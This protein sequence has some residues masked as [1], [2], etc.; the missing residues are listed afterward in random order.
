MHSLVSALLRRGTSHL[1]PD[2]ATLDRR[3][4]RPERRADD[5]LHAVLEAFFRKRLRTHGGDAASPPD[6][7]P[8]LVHRTLNRVAH[9]RAAGSRPG[10]DPL[11]PPLRRE[12]VMQ[13]A[14]IELHRL[15]EPVCSQ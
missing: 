6:R 4:D 9:R 8:L 7:V 3:T 15:D 12:E 11:Y 14:L 13:A 10:R 1:A 5:E 2:E